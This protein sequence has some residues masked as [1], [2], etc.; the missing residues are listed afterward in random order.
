LL[1]G[2]SDH[3]FE[4]NGATRGIIEARVLEKLNAAFEVAESAGSLPKADRLHIINEG[5]EISFAEALKIS[6]KI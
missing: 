2:F 4:A 5:A 6:L 3:Y 1:A